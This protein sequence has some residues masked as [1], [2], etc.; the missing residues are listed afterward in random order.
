MPFLRFSTLALDDLLNIGTRT[1]HRWGADQASRYLARIEACCNMLSKDPDLGRACDDL[2]PPG[3]RRMEQG[4]HV[5]FYR[6]IAGGIRVSR[7]L[8]ER[9]LPGRHALPDEDGP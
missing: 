8:H 4:R 9:M 5:V 6:R 7:I 3:V 1:L 2:R